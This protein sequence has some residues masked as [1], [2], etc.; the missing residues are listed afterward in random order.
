MEQRTIFITISIDEDKEDKETIQEVI[1]DIYKYVK[2][3][4][5]ESVYIDVEEL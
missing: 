4:N 2:L 1:D 5:T 3:F